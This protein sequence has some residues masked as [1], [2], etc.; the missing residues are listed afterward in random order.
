MAHR[1]K[2]EGYLLLFGILSISICLRAPFTAV[3]PLIGSIGKELGVSPSYLG[4]IT[5]LPVLVFGIT[6]PFINQF[7]RK[8]GSHFSVMM[9]L[10]FLIIGS[11]LR[12]FAGFWGLFFGTILMAV[13]IGV[14]NVLLPSIIKS[15]FPQ[16]AGMVT[17]TYVTMQ[18][19]FAGIGAGLSLPLASKFGIG[20]QM[21]LAIWIV[22]AIMAMLLWI[23]QLSAEKSRQMPLKENQFVGEKKKLSPKKKSVWTSS[24]AWYITLFFGTQSLLFYSLSNWI[25]SILVDRGLSVEVISLVATWYQWSGLPTTFL[26]PILI[27]K[28]K[29]KALLAAMIGIGYF[30]GIVLLL[31]SGT[32]VFL[33]LLALAMASAS[34]GA[35]YSLSMTMIVLVSKDAKEAGELSGMSQCAG[36]LLAAVGP[37]IS[38]ILYDYTGQ[39]TATLFFYIM[40]TV[41]LFISG[42]LVMRQSSF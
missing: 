3:G 10:L 11:L 12:S 4:M 29:N 22:A 27:Q 33:I 7:G 8:L 41:M 28:M 15:K 9:G 1:K 34:G 14:G 20:W 24:W 2:K 40:I 13:G 38:G 26:A 6:S 42:Q 16:N 37:V 21:T 36:Y 32:S 35:N 31:F 25:P 19:I 5:T 18:G 23:P 30:S 39:W 17:G